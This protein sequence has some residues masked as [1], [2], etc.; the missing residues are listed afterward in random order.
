M[1]APTKGCSV[2]W[3]VSS[4]RF[5]SERDLDAYVGRFGGQ[6]W[7]VGGALRDELLGRAPHDRDYLVTGVRADELGFNR[8]VG[9][10]F[11]VFQVQIAGKTCEVALAR[12]ERKSGKG[13]KGFSVSADNNV[14]VE[15]DLSRR[16]L[17]ANSMARNVLTGEWVDPYG[18]RRDILGRVL[19]HT[20]GAFAEDVLRP[21]RVARL[22]AALE[23]RVAPSTLDLI[24]AMRPELHHLPPERVWKETEKALEVEGSATYFKVLNAAGLLGVHFP[25]LK[26]LDVP[27]RHDG[28]ALNHTLKVLGAGRSPVERFSLLV[29][30]AGKGLTPKESHPAHHGHDALGEAP[31]RELCRR[32]RVPK[33]FETAGVLSATQH[34]RA[35]RAAEMRPGKLFRWVSDHRAH[36]QNILEVSFLDSAHREGANYDDEVA[37]FDNVRRLVQQVFH[38]EKTITGKALLAEGQEPGRQFGDI[39]FQRRVEAFEGRRMAAA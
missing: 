34:M 3:G 24:A 22:A 11:P 29:H 31:V 39:L 23:F 15:E 20:S 21:Y 28:T 33:A 12:R 18:G 27:D 1:A 10:D 19:R 8:T 4:M 38:V 16:D 37:R 2:S 32:L 14:T 7:E 30:D 36:V 17:T 25:E 13:H 6:L 26:A 9:S 5:Q 35:K